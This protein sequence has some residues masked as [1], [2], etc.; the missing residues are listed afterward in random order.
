MNCT[1]QK[2]REWTQRS[3][4]QLSLRLMC[5]YLIDVVKTILWSNKSHPKLLFMKICEQKELKWENSSQNANQ[6]VGK[7]QSL[8]QPRKFCFCMRCTH[9]NIIIM[10]QNIC[11]QCGFSLD[12]I[13]LI[14]VEKGKEIKH[15]N[16]LFL[17]RKTYILR[18]TLQVKSI[19]SSSLTEWS[20]RFCLLPYKRQAWP[21]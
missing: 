11:S 13:M 8:K 18:V 4:R 1:E 10:P 20:M 9:Y 6:S 7:M 3:I 2:A 5:I 17:P 21:Y 12:K 14:V 15:K 16:I 19:Q